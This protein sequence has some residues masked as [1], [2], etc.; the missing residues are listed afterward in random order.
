MSKVSVSLGKSIPTHTVNRQK[1][2]QKAAS[3]AESIL[4]P[5]GVE[6]ASFEQDG[7]QFA[8]SARILIE[9]DLLSGRVPQRI[10]RDGDLVVARK[11]KRRPIHRA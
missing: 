7:K 9:V 8:L 1:I 5:A 10:I 3:L 11:S 6:F 2:A 4:L